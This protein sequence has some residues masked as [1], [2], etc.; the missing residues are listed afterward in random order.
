MCEMLRPAEY[1][2]SRQINEPLPVLLGRISER[3]LV[4][5]EGF[6]HALAGSHERLCPQST[7]GLKVARDAR[8]ITGRE[9]V[10]TL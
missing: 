9:Y 8:I 3:V 10:C 2:G 1:H 4:Q 5:S 7:L 6:S